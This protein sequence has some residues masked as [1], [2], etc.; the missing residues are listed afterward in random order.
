M[1]LRR[2]WLPASSVPSVACSHLFRLFLYS[3]KSSRRQSTTGAEKRLEG[4]ERTSIWQF[5]T[6]SSI[7]QPSENKCYCFVIVS[8][9][10]IRRQSVIFTRLEWHMNDMQVDSLT[11]SLGLPLTPLCLS[12]EEVWVWQWSAGC[13]QINCCLC[14]QHFTD[15]II[16]V[17]LSTNYSRKIIIHLQSKIPAITKWTTFT[18]NQKFQ[19]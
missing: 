4:L 2:I 6:P 7:L 9:F 3:S 18:V 19:A 5:T 12:V 13:C 10:V 15:F 8:L 1:L 11:V 16:N 14:L 17:F